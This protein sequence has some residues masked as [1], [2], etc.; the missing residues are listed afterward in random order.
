MV[1]CESELLITFLLSSLALLFP[2]LWHVPSPTECTSARLVI[3]FLLPIVKD[4]Y[5]E[6]CGLWR[7][8]ASESKVGT[9]CVVIG[10][11]SKRGRVMS[12]LSTSSLLSAGMLPPISTLCLTNNPISYPWSRHRGESSSS[13]P[14]SLECSSAAHICVLR[15]LGFFLVAL[16]LFAST[17]QICFRSVLLPSSSTHSEARGQQWELHSPALLCSWPFPLKS[18]WFKAVVNASSSLRAI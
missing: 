1:F 5:G 6:G 4:T 9:G 10:W 17:T 7:K 3:I 15:S 12:T 14:C 16:R 8:C 2:T 13:C 18:L 11:V